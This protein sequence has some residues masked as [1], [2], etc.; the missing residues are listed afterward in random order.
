MKRLLQ[1]DIASEA[2]GTTVPVQLR[3]HL[4]VFMR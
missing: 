1:F 4:G 3:G 2:P